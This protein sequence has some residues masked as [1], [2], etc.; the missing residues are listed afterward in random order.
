MR[1]ATAGF[2]A[3]S[4]M[5]FEYTSNVRDVIAELDAAAAEAKP[6]VVR[7]LNKMADR[8]KVRAARLV[9]DAGYKLKIGDIKAAIKI[10]RASAGRLRADAVASGRPL[11][12]V[13]YGAR[14]TA[15]GVSVDV[16]NGRKVVAHAFI[17]STANGSRQVFVREPGAVHRKVVRGGKPVWTALPIRKLYGPSIPD[18]LLNKSVE[19][20]IVDMI[21]EQFPALLAHEHDYLRRRLARLPPVPS[22]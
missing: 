16:L 21:A 19:R 14:Q 12:L 11:P 9:R 7:A 18:A 1:P 6:A 17:A 5:R 3:G 8:I 20:A 13:K 15:D 22:E 4:S 2:F 10:Q